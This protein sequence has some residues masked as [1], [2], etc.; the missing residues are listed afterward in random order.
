M[1][2]HEWVFHDLGRFAEEHHLCGSLS[3]YADEPTSDGYVVWIAYSCGV[4]FERCVTPE[5][6]EYD[7][8]RTRLLTSQN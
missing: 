6:A 2:D 5:A 1:D 3:G 4:L 8:L 7:L